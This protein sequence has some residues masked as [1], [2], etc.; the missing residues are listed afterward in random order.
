MSV[1]KETGVV[2]KDYNLTA[3]KTVCEN[4][5]VN[6]ITYPFFKKETG[7]ELGKEIDV[8]RQ[9]VYELKTKEELRDK[10]T[11]ESK[12]WSSYQ[13]CIGGV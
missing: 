9:A 5:T 12:D 10:C 1:N 8:L 6:T 7:V 4:K 3:T 2:I 13:L 11:A